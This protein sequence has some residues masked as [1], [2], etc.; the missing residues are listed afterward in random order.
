MG[1]A[2]MYIVVSCDSQLSD[3][4]EFK[5]FGR[6]WMVIV[7]THVKEI[8]MAVLMTQKANSCNFYFD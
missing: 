3:C 1:S 7:P 8:E 4:F 2:I 6:L 5:V